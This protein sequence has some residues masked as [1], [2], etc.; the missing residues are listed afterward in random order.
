MEEY[1]LCYDPKSKAL[2]IKRFVRA[3]YLKAFLRQGKYQLVNPEIE[4]ISKK[5]QLEKALEV[6]K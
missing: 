1:D 2:Y 5:S 4:R 6:S 3:G